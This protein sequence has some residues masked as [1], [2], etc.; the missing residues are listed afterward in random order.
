MNEPMGRSVLQARA[1]AAHRVG[2]G[3]NR[4]VLPDHALVHLVFEAEEFR[5]SGFEH[6]PYGYARPLRDDFG[7]VLV[8]D[9]LLEHPILRRRLPELLRLGGEPLFQPDDFWGSPYRISRHLAEVA[10]PLVAFGVQ[11]E[12][13]LHFLL[14]GWI[15]SIRSFSFCHWTRS[16]SRSVL[17]N[18]APSRA[19]RAARR[20]SSSV[21]RFSASRSI[22]S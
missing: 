9:L 13:A 10:L 18:P 20:S 15:S 17:R 1:G 8:G 6:P 2:D 22:S 3:D 19:P 12:P 7:D 14:Y 21:S 4:V 16:L 11:L 5:A